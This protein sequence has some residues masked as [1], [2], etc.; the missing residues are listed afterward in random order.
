V[1]STEP[2]DHWRVYQGRRRTFHGW[3]SGGGYSFRSMSHEMNFLGRPPSGVIPKGM[4][5]VVDQYRVVVE[6]SG[7]AYKGVSRKE[8]NRLFSLAVIQSKS[9]KSQSDQ[10]SITLFRDYEIVREY[11]PSDRLLDSKRVKDLVRP[12]RRP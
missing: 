4:N 11:N 9:A 6:V 12:I 1:R 3:T 7:I 5:A 8:A 2:S 10:R